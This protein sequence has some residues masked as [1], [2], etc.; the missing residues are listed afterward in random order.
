MPEAK[1]SKGSR[2]PFGEDRRVAPALAAL[3]ELYGLLI[4]CVRNG[5][6]R[7]L[8]SFGLDAAGMQALRARAEH[9]GFRADVSGETLCVWK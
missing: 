3:H 1:V 6:A 9:E 8:H 2:Q 5:G 7:T 4:A